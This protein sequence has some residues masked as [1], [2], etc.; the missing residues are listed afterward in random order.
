M[1]WIMFGDYLLNPDTGAVF[2]TCGSLLK[3][4]KENMCITVPSQEDSETQQ[5]FE[6]LKKMLIPSYV[7]KEE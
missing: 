3:Y 6:R 1:T 7:S 5:R 4:Q 2:S